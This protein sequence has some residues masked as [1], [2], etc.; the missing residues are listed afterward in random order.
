MV[1]NIQLCGIKFSNMDKEQIIKPVCVQ[2]YISG[3]IIAT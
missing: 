2:E 1:D 3:V